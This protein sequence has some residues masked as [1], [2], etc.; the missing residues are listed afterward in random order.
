[1]AWCGANPHHVR[2]SGRLSQ[3]T[4]GDVLGS[5]CRAKLSGRVQLTET[6]GVTAGRVHGIHLSR[7]QVISIDS[8]TELDELFRLEDAILSF[9]VACAAPPVALGPLDP[10]DVLRGRPRARDR[11]APKPPCGCESQRREALRVLGLGQDADSA[12]VTRAFRALA[13]RL[14]PDRHADATE[15]ERRDLHRRF[16]AVSAAYHRLAS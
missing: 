11:A 8:G 2:I 10:G 1:V 4:L 9:H 12:D 15:A 5:L 7:G 14:H 16:A 3:T 6:R 13:A